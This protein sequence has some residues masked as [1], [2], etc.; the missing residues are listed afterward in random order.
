[1]ETVDGRAPLETFSERVQHVD[2]NL[3]ELRHELGNLVLIAG[4]AAPDQ[5]PRL[6][7]VAHLVETALF[8]LRSP[9]P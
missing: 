8:L 6:R 9:T 7:H 5:A 4:R 3:D 1:M 2:T